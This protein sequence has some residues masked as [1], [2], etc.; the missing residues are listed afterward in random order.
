MTEQDIHLRDDDHRSRDRRGRSQDNRS[1][2][3]SKSR[4][5]RSSSHHEKSR[6][7]SHSRERNEN[8][9]QN[10]EVSLVQYNQPQNQNNDRRMMIPPAPPQPKPKELWTEITK[11]LVS[12]EAIEY[13]GYEFEETAEFFYVMNYLEYVRPSCDFSLLRMILTLFQEDVTR[14]VELSEELHRDRRERIDQIQWE[15]KDPRLPE[16]RPAPPEPPRMRALGPPDDPRRPGPR[17]WDERVY[18]REVIYDDGT[19]RRYRM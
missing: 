11:D 8:S 10:V 3:R 6:S 17:E 16:P 14:L 7:R 15:R 4:R 2:Y 19:R 12:K 13:M 18:E 5:R 1:R 9:N